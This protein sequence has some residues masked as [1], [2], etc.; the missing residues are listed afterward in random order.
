MFGLFKKNIGSLELCVIFI[1]IVTP[2]IENH[3]KELVNV[4]FVEEKVKKFI[5]ESNKKLSDEQLI[6]INY[7]SQILGLNKGLQEKITQL[8]HSSEEDTKVKFVE[9]WDEFKSYGCFC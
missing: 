1:K 6:T 4:G 9:I 3:K 5:Q 7:A 2:L 8:N